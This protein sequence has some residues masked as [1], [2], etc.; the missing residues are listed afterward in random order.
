MKI[1]LW[2]R[3]LAAAVIG[4]VVSSAAQAVVAG[5]VQSGQIKGAA[6]AG[7]LLTAGAYLSKSPLS[8]PESDSTAKK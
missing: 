6:I 3:G 2:L 1:G 5:S 8:A 7:A 4:G